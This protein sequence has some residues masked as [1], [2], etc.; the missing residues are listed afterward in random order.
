MKSTSFLPILDELLTRSGLLLGNCPDRLSTAEVASEIRT[1]ADE[2]IEMRLFYH[3]DE[4]SD[5]MR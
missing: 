5:E 2:K 1:F 4:V 3:E